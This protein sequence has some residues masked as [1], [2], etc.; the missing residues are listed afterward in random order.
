MILDRTEFLAEL[1]DY[2]HDERTKLMMYKNRPLLGMIP[3]RTDWQGANWE[4][5]IQHGVIQGGSSTFSKAQDN[6]YA[7]LHKRFTIP[8]KKYYALADVDNS[9]IDTSTSDKGAFLRALTSEIDGAFVHFANETARQLYGSGSGL[10]GVATAGAETTSVTF[11]A[12]DIV[13]FEVGMKVVAADDEAGTS[14]VGSASTVTAVNRTTGVVTLSGAQNTGVGDSEYYFRE[15]DFNLQLQGLAAWLTDDATALGASF[16]GVT[17]SV[18]PTRLAGVFYDGSGDT[19]EDAI[20][21]A[22]AIGFRE[23]AM[24]DICVMNPVNVAAL[25]RLLESGTKH[26]SRFDKVKSADA[27]LGFDSIRFHTAA[28]V[29]DVVSDPYCPLDKAYMLDLSTWS[30]RSAGTWGKFLNHGSQAQGILRNTS[31]DSIEF[32]IGGYGNIGCSA[33]G[34]NIVVKLA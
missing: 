27:E 22:G 12:S 33:P 24:P 13:N 23:G 8:L 16:N 4:L 7:S 30:L 3:K 17:R 32:R 26:R 10:R 31:S 11:S 9:V 25:D 19:I 5:P 1:K 15:G 2:Y 29:V 28:G 18:D 6:K 14:L 34:K 21:N 20:I